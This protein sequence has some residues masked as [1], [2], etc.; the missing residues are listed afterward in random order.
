[1]FWLRLGISGTASVLIVY[2]PFVCYGLRHMEDLATYFGGTS[3]EY[4]EAFSGYERPGS[5][6]CLMQSVTR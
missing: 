2:I 3:M 4:V 5:V 6:I 1:M